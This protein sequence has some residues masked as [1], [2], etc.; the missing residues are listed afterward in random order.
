MP[1]RQ[2]GARRAASRSVCLCLLLSACA[3]GET[4]I[5]I[6]IGG[7]EFSVEVARTDSERARGLM[8]RKSLGAREG[9]LFVFDRDDH[10][11]FWM[12]N[13][14]IPLSIAFLS[15]EGRILEI[16]DMEPFSEKTVRSRLSSRFALEV[17]RGKFN[18]AGVKE[19]D[20][21]ILPPDFQ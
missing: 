13:T 2:R 3:G 1:S 17:N 18:E 12:K 8:H 20:A 16:V 4:R 5:P 6:A 7:M 21:V 14:S 15:P 11:A 9:M 19:G 10:L